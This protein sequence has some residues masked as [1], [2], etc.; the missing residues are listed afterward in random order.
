MDGQGSG[1]AS[2]SRLGNGSNGAV[3]V[4]APHVHAVAGRRAHVHAVA[5]RGAQHKGWQGIRA[6]TR[7]QGGKDPRFTVLRGMR[8]S[9][10]RTHA[11]HHTGGSRFRPADVPH[12]GRYRFLGY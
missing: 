10:P 2:R 1:G 4:S 6:G 12:C 5:G 8:V 7:I 9:E 3:R 11:Q